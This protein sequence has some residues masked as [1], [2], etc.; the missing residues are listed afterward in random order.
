MGRA[1][2]GD[3]ISRVMP[4][5]I[6]H[7]AE[8]DADL[9]AG[10]TVL[11][12]CCAYNWFATAI[13]LVRASANVNARWMDYPWGVVRPLELCCSLYS[14]EHQ[15][16]HFL[17]PRPWSGSR[18]LGGS[19]PI[20]PENAESTRLALAKA[21]IKAGA[22]VHPYAI[23]SQSPLTLAI[24][25]PSTAIAEI[26]I[27]A[28]ASPNDRDGQGFTTLMRVCS[29]RR[30][31]G[32]SKPDQMVKWLL[33]HGA[34]V[35]VTRSPQPS[36]LVLLASMGAHFTHH[37][38]AMYKALLEHGADANAVDANGLSA[39][40]IGAKTYDFEACHMLLAYGARPS[41]SDFK[42]IFSDLVEKSFDDRFQKACTGDPESHKE[43][44]GYWVWSWDLARRFRRLL[45]LDKDQIILA[46]LTNLDLAFSWRLFPIAKALLE[47]QHAKD[48]SWIQEHG[49]KYLKSLTSCKTHHQGHR[50]RLSPEEP[51]SVC[52]YRRDL[53]SCLIA[54]GTDPNIGEPVQYALERREWGFASL[55]VSKGAR[56]VPLKRFMSSE[57]LEDEL[58][59]HVECSLWSEDIQEMTDFGFREPDGP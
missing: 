40:V 36:A 43:L 46:D 34:Q 5:L 31:P 12:D 25:L 56:K 2:R 16:R 48:P 15:P 21:L 50:G 59:D 52:C 4:W 49:P 17:W 42:L 9:G 11:H 3:T 45:K 41:P 24:A 29:E 55:L 35:D 19:R 44:E 54:L 33:D 22:S 30:T 51:L 8:V 14:D 23:C 7:G 28:G 13:E 37:R 58:E 10:R 18:V 27:G 1:A 38:K 47:R 32:A 26:L 20:T 53:A 6:Q 39:F 57:E